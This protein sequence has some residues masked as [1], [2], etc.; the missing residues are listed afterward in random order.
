MKESLK[1]EGGVDV[2]H[3]QDGKIVKKLTYS[4]STI[5]IDGERISLR[6]SN[7]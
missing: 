1:S 5:E 3:F 2:L 7:K 6:A 4:K